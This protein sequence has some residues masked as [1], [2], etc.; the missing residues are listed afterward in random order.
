MN[1]TSAGHLSFVLHCHLPFVRHPEHEY[2]LEEQWL[3]EAVL[4]TYLPLLDVF[5]DLTRKKIPYKATLSISPTLLAMW[6]D[7]LLQERT[8]R[9]MDDLSEL[10]EK[11]W[12]RVAPLPDFQPVVQMYRTKLGHFRK[13]FEKEYQRDITRG[14][15]KL[16]R[17]G[18]LE[19]MACAAT[20]GYLP[21]LSVR[22]SAVNAQMEVALKAYREVFGSGPEGFW[23]PECGFIP[24]LDQVLK[25]HGLRYFLLDTHGLLH[26]R[27]QAKFGSFAPVRCASG[28]S[29]FARDAES[30]KEVWSSKEGYP[31]DPDYREFYR[32]VGWDLGEEYLL[33]YVRPEGVRRFT[34]LKYYRVTGGEAPKEPYQPEKALAKV[35]EHAR[36]FLFKRQRQM[37]G[38][39]KSM[40]RLPSIVCMYD[41][42]LFGHW[43]YEGPEFL[44]SLFEINHQENLAIQFKTPSQVLDLQPELQTVEPSTSS[45]GFGGY[46]NFWLNETNDW[47]YP[48]LTKACD[49]M[50]ELT[51]L[52]PSARGTM[53]SALD[54]A[55]RELLLA[56]ASDWAFMM[57]TG[58]FKAYAQGRVRTHLERFDNLYDQIKTRRINKEMLGDLGK[59]D[60][61]FPWIDYR[62]FQLSSKSR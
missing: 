42:E 26:S 18:N 29:V 38:I 32:D 21:L 40:D 37:D 45:W 25:D 52:F 5:E 36:D 35:K 54:Q 55:A 57:K 11:E 61:L 47:I 4:E 59:R 39:G 51:V 27:P 1:P 7:T 14:L 34:G 46:S 49:K 62:A 60:N 17:T 44:K 50:M 8:L 15:K 30:S 6:Q 9:Y 33:P 43:W 53:R 3:F 23:L 19:I 10:C 58:H 56:Q 31:G 2:F 12:E 28:I 24:G 20:H 41:A 16:K 13:K 48:L 22:Q